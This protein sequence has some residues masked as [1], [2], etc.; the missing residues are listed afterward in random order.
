[1][2]EIGHASLYLLDLDAALKH[3]QAARALAPNHADLLADEADGLTHLSRHED[4]EGKI[5][6]ALSLNPLAPDDYYW[7]G[8]A[9]SFF[10]GRYGEALARLG[11]MRAP[12]HALRLMAACAAMNGDPELAT[13]Y[14]RRALERDP[15]FAVD[16]WQSLYPEPDRADTDHYLH[17]LRLAGFPGTSF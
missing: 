7:I 5:S 10:R 14:R 3:Y 16:K 17:A 8:G 11:A 13:D 2:R 15:T 4:A 1:M 6:R 9:V 12:G